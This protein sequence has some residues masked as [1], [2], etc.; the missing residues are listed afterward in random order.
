MAEPQLARVAEVVRNVVAEQ[1]EGALDPGAGGDRGLRGAAQVGVVEVDQPV[2]GRAHLAALPQLL[3]GVTLGSAP[4]RRSIAPIA[5]PSRMTTR[6]TPRTSRAFAEIPSRPAAPTSA[7][8]DSLPGQVTSRAAER[9]GSVSEPCARNAPRQTAASS[10]REPVVS[11]LGRPR[12]GRRRASSR[13][14]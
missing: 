12:T 14:V 6:C 7:I 10:S 11:R 1:L 9:P 2:G 13:P 5:S 8:A 3:P 4:M